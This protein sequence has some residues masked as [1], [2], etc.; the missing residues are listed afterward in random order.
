MPQHENNYEKVNFQFKQGYFE[1][2]V[3]VDLRTGDVYEIPDKDWNRE[4]TK[5]TFYNIPVYDS[6]V[7]IADRSVLYLE[8]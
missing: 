1:D 3:Y 4:G 5:Y 2:P 7:M 8:N 6:P